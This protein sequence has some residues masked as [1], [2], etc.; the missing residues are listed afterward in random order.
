[1]T[2]EENKAMDKKKAENI[3][4]ELKDVL[5]NEDKREWLKLF[6]NVW[7]GGNDNE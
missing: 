3:D 6:L 2:D 5:S 7:H 4:K 1:M